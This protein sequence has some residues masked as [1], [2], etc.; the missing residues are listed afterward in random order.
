M[1][2]NRKFGCEIEIANRNV[3]DMAQILRDAGF[4][5]FSREDCS[6]NS[7]PLMVSTDLAP[8][9]VYSLPEYKT[10]WKV[11]YDGSV[12]DGCEVVSPVLSG[13]QGLEAVKN[14]VKA[15]NKAGA[16]ADARCGLHVHVDGNDLSIVELLN[17]ARRYAAHE[18]MID[19]FIDPSRRG[20]KNTYCHSMEAVVTMMA[21][22]P[23]TN[24]K[25]YLK[26]L[27]GRY[28][29]LNVQ[30]YLR[31]GTVEFRQL[32][33]TTSWTKIVNWIEFCVSFVEASRMDKETVKSI[34]AESAERTARIPEE[35]RQFI[36]I[37]RIDRW[38]LAY[39]LKIYEYEVPSAVARFN[40]LLPGTFT[41]LVAKYPNS[42][43]WEVKI[44]FAKLPLHEV[45]GTWDKGIAPNVVSFL[46]HL[47]S[48]HAASPS[49][50]S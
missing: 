50:S 20:D 33:G 41:P 49:V 23:F 29:K 19:S 6:L 2:T 40:K 42:E 28:F 38:N 10:A 47:A 48:T 12:D 37:Q 46:H 8:S 24:D 17:V 43:I 25:E 9:Q 27:G 11:V 22:T 14:V 26:R 21:E 1:M 34:Q 16:K 15:M 4:N 30:A 39:Y 36:G 32:E 44:P 5:V 13:I 45:S 18:K 31:H 3:R 35:L 7:G